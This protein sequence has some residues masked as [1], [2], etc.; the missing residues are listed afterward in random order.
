[1]ANQHWYQLVVFAAAAGIKTTLQIPQSR[2]GKG[3]L[4]QT[5]G[6]TYSTAKMA[7]VA[8]A[9]MK[10]QCSRSQDSQA[11]LEYLR[12]VCMQ[13]IV[14]V[15]EKWERL[16]DNQILIFKGADAALDLLGKPQPAIKAAIKRSIT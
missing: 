6:F 9:A 2:P 1:V 7:L 5:S 16:K 12:D 4:H 15:A 10:D 14:R 11:A 8:L 3:L 13:N